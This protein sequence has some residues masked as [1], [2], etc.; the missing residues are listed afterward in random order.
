MTFSLPSLKTAG[1]AFMVAA[2]LGTSGFVAAPA[3]AQNPPAFNFQFGIGSDGQPR[4]GVGI[5]NDDRGRWR[6]GFCMSDNQ[7]VRALRAD[8][9]RDIDVERSNRRTAW[10]EARDGRWQYDLRVNK[11]T[12]DVDVLDRDPIRR[13]RR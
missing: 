5:G 4:F 6:R 9:Y 13:G 10:V 3:M 11:C 1:R 7:V 12:G 8:G 2:V